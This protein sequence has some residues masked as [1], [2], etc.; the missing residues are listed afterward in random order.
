MGADGTS[1]NRGPVYVIDLQ[2]GVK[3]CTIPSSVWG[4]SDWIEGDY[5]L[6]ESSGY[7]ASNI[8]MW[9]ND[10]LE[11]M[12]WINYSYMTSAEGCSNDFVLNHGGSSWMILPE[13]RYYNYRS[14]GETGLYENG[15]FFDV[16]ASPNVIPSLAGIEQRG[17]FREWINSAGGYEEAFPEFDFRVY[18]NTSTNS[19][20]DIRPIDP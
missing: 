2:T 11:N 9:M 8:E 5:L 3:Y 14:S 6:I 7:S 13:D 19:V 4:C 12:T 17:D 10:D 1:N 16:I 20:S 15:I 18:V